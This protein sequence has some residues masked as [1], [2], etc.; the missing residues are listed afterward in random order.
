MLY[1]YM[2][3]NIHTYIYM[4]I[5]I[6]IYIYVYIYVHCVYSCICIN[7]RTSITGNSI[8]AAGTTEINSD[9]ANNCAA[10]R[11]TAYNTLKALECPSANI[12]NELGGRTLQ[13]GVYCDAEA[14]MTLTA[15]DL[16]L[17][18][19]ATDIFIFQASSS[20]FAYPY[21]KVI[22][23]GNVK[24]T[25]VFWAVGSSATIG[26]S[27][28]FVGTTYTMLLYISYKILNIKKYN[29]NALI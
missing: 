24:A 13:A 3:I 4:Y 21:T 18:G 14:P 26:T 11:I 29:I 16:T 1:I 22:L 19:S 28:K 25:N 12:G 6:Y 20:F 5:Y 2:Y 23:A 17:D 9:V 7:I 15:G 27:S 10:H 8:L